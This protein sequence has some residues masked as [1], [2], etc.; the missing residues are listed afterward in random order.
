[1]CTLAPTIKVKVRMKFGT[2][3]CLMVKIIVGKLEK[4]SNSF[5][6]VWTL[7]DNL[8]HYFLPTVFSFI[9]SPG[10]FSTILI[11]R[12]NRIFYL[13]VLLC[14][15]SFIL[16]IISFVGEDNNYCFIWNIEDKQLQKRH[17]KTL[18]RRYSTFQL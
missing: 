15:F 7:F 14:T 16:L 8:S 18:N 3:K 11:K 6:M 9:S 1:L 17:L 13:N 4:M 2:F 5:L 10:F 12:I